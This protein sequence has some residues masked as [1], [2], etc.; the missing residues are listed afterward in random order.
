MATCTIATDFART[1]RRDRDF[2]ALHDEYLYGPMSVAEFVAWTRDM[3]LDL[4]ASDEVAS[5]V[6]DDLCIPF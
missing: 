4:G 6:A 2:Q 5:L 1:L 3:A